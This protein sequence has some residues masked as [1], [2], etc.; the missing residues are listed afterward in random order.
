[1]CRQ[2][3]DT[4]TCTGNGNSLYCSEKCQKKDWHLDKKEA[5]TH[6]P[7]LL[8]PSNGNKPVFTSFPGPAGSRNLFQGL[9]ILNGISFYQVCNPKVPNKGGGTCTCVHV[10]HKVYGFKDSSCTKVCRYDLFATSY[11]PSCAFHKKP[12]YFVHATFRDLGNLPVLLS[13]KLPISPNLIVPQRACWAPFKRGDGSA[14]DGVMLKTTI[15]KKYKSADAY[16]LYGR[17]ESMWTMFRSILMSLL[18]FLAP[19]YKHTIR[20]ALRRSYQNRH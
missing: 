3:T 16:R 5:V 8:L 11:K 2:T 19:R 18:P 12:R 17:V 20:V 15:D 6:T 13:Q 1:M 4:R 14:G 10:T 9:V 7:G